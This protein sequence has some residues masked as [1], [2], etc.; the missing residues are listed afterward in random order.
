MKWV[1]DVV[2]TDWSPE[3]RKKIVDRFHPEH[4]SL[5]QKIYWNLVSGRGNFTFF[6]AR[7]TR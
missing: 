3:D 7:N 1:N 5:F 6:N 2:E 4:D